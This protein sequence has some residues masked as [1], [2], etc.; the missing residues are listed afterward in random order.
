MK[1][2]LT[3]CLPLALCVL[4]P[5]LSGQTPKSK[6]SPFTNDQS[7]FDRLENDVERCRQVIMT[8]KANDLK[9]DQ[10]K[11]IDDSVVVCRH[12]LAVIDQDLM[13]IKRKQSLSLD[14]ELATELM[15]LESSVNSLMYTYIVYTYN[16]QTAKWLDELL[17][18]RDKLVPTILAFRAHI[19]K[20]MT[21]TDAILK[22]K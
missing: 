15:V 5:V 13:L 14:F 21:A 7:L 18:A 17:S 16:G 22:D 10:K 9:Y 19:Q 6:T 2:K 12:S 1:I 3:T 11:T 4:V 8:V 20:I